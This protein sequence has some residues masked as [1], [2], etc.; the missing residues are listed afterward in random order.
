LPLLEAIEV[1]A[2]VQHW[3]SMLTERHRIV[4]ERRF[5][6]NGHEIVSLGCL[7]DEL[8]L[9]PERVRQIQI[10]ALK[11]LRNLLIQTKELK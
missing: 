7:A 4:I 10:D 5:G 3:L 11:S 6:L 1:E 2:R 9:S 8:G